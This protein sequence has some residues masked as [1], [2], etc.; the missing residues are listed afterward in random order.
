MSSSTPGRNSTEGL[1]PGNSITICTS[2]N[3]RPLRYAG[4]GV[5]GYPV[6]RTRTVPESRDPVQIMTCHVT[7]T[8]R[9]S[10][11]TSSS[12]GYHWQYQLRLI[13]DEERRYSGTSSSTI[14]SGLWEN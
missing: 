6:P 9:R 1:G 8:S 2:R 11:G 10:A 4:T 7:G 14:S 3:P 12:T 5:P 13:E